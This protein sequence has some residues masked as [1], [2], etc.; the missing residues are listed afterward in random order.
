MALDA[1][2]TLLIV[3]FAGLAVLPT[4]SGWIRV[5]VVV[6]E[7]VFGMLIGV[8]WLN[9]VPDHSIIQFFSSFGLTY[10]MFLAGLEVDPD[11]LRRHLGTTA[12]I[13]AA[14]IAGPFLVGA[15]LAGALGSSPLLVGTI[16]STTSLSLV[17]PLTREVENRDETMALLL[18]SVVLVDIASIFILGMVLALE[19][20]VLGM[21]FV[22]NLAGVLG[23]FLI[24]LLVGWEPIRRPL[25][26]WLFPR[27]QFEDA[28]RFSFALIFLLGA[29]ASQL[30][31]HTILGSF[32]AGLA[33]REITPR[34]SKLPDRLESFG[35]GFF[36]PLFFIFVGAK[37][38]VPGLLSNLSAVALLSAVLLLA[39]GA[40][41]VSVTAAAR[42]RGLASRESLAFGF[43]HS[44]R[45]SLI[46]AAADVAR[47]LG[48]VSETLFSTFILLAVVSALVGPSVGRFLLSTP[49]TGSGPTTPGADAG[50]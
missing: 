23:L 37:V 45:V 47:T 39:V 46:L 27:A 33:I 22:W 20:G 14:S 38:D 43:V 7:I 18:G 48:L 10:L 50:D 25:Q 40:K 41:V 34:T 8:S 9:L 15:L 3:V 4:L 5:P 32:V 2:T 30:G 11:L 24:P 16:F 49:S 28:V 42:L 31:Y 35:Y 13:A 1:L 26:R 19:Q 12:T 29:L 6:T 44:A 21:A 36:L 17:L